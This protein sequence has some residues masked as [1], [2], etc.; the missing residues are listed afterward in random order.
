ML[1]KERLFK[2]VDM[3]L[4]SVWYNHTIDACPEKLGKL[5]AYSDIHKRI[6]DGEFDVKENN[7]D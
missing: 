5:R 6:K 3:M 4:D 2:Y 7:Y 1:D